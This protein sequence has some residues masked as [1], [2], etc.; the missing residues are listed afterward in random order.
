MLLFLKDKFF[1]SE[2]DHAL[3]VPFLHCSFTQVLVKNT[4]PL[5]LYLIAKF[6]ELSF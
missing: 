3:R 4:V 1:H 6:Y 5:N 2:K